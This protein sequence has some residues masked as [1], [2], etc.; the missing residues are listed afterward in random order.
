[1]T[2][3]KFIEL[4]GTST[5][6]WE[7]AAKQALEEASESLKGIRVAEVT[8][9]DLKVIG[10]SITYRVRMNV[11]FKVTSLKRYAELLNVQRSELGSIYPEED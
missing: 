5:K 6:S 10:A 2:M 3:Y 4:V 1:M 11:S 8:R 7:D 9:M